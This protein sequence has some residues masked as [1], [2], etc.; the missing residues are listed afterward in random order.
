MEVTKIWKLL[1]IIH[2]DNE[3]VQPIYDRK[4]KFLILDGL[5]GTFYFHFKN[6]TVF[7]PWAEQQF[8]IKRDFKEV[9]TLFTTINNYCIGL[10]RGFKRYLFIKGLGY[11]SRKKKN[12][13]LFKLGYSHL[14]RYKIPVGIRLK[15]IKKNK[16]KLI[17]INWQLL[18]Q[19]TEVIR[20]FKVPDVY[21]AKGIRYKGQQFKLKLGK[22]SKR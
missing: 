15:R 16:I 13:I 12:W 14:I 19:I 9:Q 22:R 3:A 4:N 7:Y 2:T 20:A 10:I 5:F 17:S 18:K 6:V 21:K 1:D 8:I 11:R